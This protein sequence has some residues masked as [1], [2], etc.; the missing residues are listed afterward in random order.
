MSGDSISAPKFNR[1]NLGLNLQVST[2]PTTD[3]N[4]SNLGAIAVRQVNYQSKEWNRLEQLVF[5]MSES[6]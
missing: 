2:A 4:D 1:E 6:F 3:V 5:S